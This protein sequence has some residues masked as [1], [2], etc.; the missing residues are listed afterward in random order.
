M[1]PPVPSEPRSFSLWMFRFET[2]NAL[3]VVVFFFSLYDLTV[4]LRVN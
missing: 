4:D 2:V 1:V 3:T